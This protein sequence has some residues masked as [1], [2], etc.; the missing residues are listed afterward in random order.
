[1]TMSSTLCFSAMSHLYLREVLSLNKIPSRVI[2]LNLIPFFIS[3]LLFGYSVIDSVWPESL[4]ISEGGI[5]FL[6]QTGREIRTLVLA[7]YLLLDLYLMWKYRGELVR[8]QGTVSGS[9]LVYFIVHKILL[10]SLILFSGRL[11]ILQNMSIYIGLLSMPAALAVIT[12]YKVLVG[13]SRK[14]KNLE[15]TLENY[16]R[17]KVVGTGQKYAKSNADDE[18]Y[19]AIAQQVENH[20]A[21]EKPYLDMFILGRT[22]GTGIA[23]ITV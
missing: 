5:S 23:G 14:A 3:V 11:G 17:D 12:Y 2:L 20:M 8:S 9:I 7:F 22:T 21:S 1:M 10:M 19:K 16:L 6:A 13:I 15:T 18:K 4:P